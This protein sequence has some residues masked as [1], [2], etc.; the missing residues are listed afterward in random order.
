MVPIFLNPRARSSV[1]LAVRATRSFN[2][3]LEKEVDLEIQNFQLDLVSYT[4]VR[5]GSMRAAE[6]QKICLTEG[7][8]KTPVHEE[9]PGELQYYKGRSDLDSDD[10]MRFVREKALGFT[11][12][13]EH[14][15]IT[16]P[17]HTCIVP[18]FT[19][20]NIFRAYSLK[21]EYLHFKKDGIPVELINW[22]SP[23][24]I[25]RPRRE[26][27]GC[28]RGSSGVVDS[29]NTVDG[30]EAMGLAEITILEPPPAYSV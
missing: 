16:T 10:Y 15:P 23:E 3:G 14:A 21:M 29:A 12:L 1:Q 17:Y 28:I 9:D 26:G 2:D 30:H 24:V 27:H 20:Y 18:E 25:A 11:H 5:A 19:T 8:S 7:K 22:G 6:S 4:K 13:E